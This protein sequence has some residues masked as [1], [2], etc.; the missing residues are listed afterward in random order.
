[1]GLKKYDIEVRT[2]DDTGS[3]TDANVFLSVFGN[4]GELK[5]IKLEKPLNNKNPFEAGSLDKF[6]LNL[7][8]VGKV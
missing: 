4:K 2:G 8:D 3:G 5:D 1:V 6:S 7:K